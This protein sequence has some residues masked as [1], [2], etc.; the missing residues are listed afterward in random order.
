MDHHN[1]LLSIN[2]L[3][4]NGLHYCI[5]LYTES[6]VLKIRQIKCKSY[7]KICISYCIISSKFTC[8]NILPHKIT[9]EFLHISFIQ[10]VKMKCSLKWCNCSQCDVE[11]DS[12]LPG[13]MINILSIRVDISSQLYVTFKPCTSRHHICSSTELQP[14]Q[15]INITCITWMMHE[16]ILTLD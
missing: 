9:T 11:G 1:A 4:H 12:T 16:L 10:I 15:Q 13:L 5:T 7:N 3:S 6:H 2:S 14:V 8:C